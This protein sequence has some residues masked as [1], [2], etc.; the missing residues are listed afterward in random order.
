MVLIDPLFQRALVRVCRKLQI[1]V[2]YDEIFVGLY[3]LGQESAS[4]F[5][6]V[7]SSF[8]FGFPFLC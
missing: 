8:P 7:F 6:G 3:R 2:I 5:L 4:S 1:P